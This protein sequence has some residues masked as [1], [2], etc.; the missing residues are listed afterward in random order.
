MGDD[1]LL[2][3]T[4]RMTPSAR[5]ISGGANGLDGGAA[6]NNGVN[7]GGGREGDGEE[8]EGGRASIP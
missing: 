4:W 6:M 1:I 3:S 8:R 7:G 5:G 2:N